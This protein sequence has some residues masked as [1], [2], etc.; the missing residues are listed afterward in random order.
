MSGVTNT[1]EYREMMERKAMIS[2]M[3]CSVESLLRERKTQALEK[4]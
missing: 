2:V 4:S 3:F 1:T